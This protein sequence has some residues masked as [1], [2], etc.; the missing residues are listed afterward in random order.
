M[1]ATCEILCNNA[2][3]VA[4]NRRVNKSGGSV[5]CFFGRGSFFEKR[6]N[7]KRGL[8]LREKKEGERE[9]ERGEGRIERWRER[10]GEERN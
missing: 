9:E 3:N 7:R 5:E 1:V 2:E 10:E 8:G 4:A 6:E